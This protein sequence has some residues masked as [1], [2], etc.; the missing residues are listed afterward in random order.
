MKHEPGSEIVT[1]SAAVKI[2]TKNRHSI[3]REMDTDLMGSAG[4][5]HSLDP[6]SHG[7][8]L[9]HAK[10]SLRKIASRVDR[11]IPGTLSSRRHLSKA[12]PDRPFFLTLAAD[13]RLR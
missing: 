2:V 11:P 1:V 10:S 7:I 4:L 8:F 5:W 9:D 6:Q 13:P 3:F 12:I